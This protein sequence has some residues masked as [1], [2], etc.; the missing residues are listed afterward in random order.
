RRG[1][2]GAETWLCRAP[3]TAP[4]ALP[5]H[6]LLAGASG[7]LAIGRFLQQQLAAR[8]AIAPVTPFQVVDPG[9][10]VLRRRQQ[11]ADQLASLDGD[12]TV[13]LQETAHPGAIAQRLDPQQR[14]RHLARADAR[15]PLA[16]VAQQPVL[17]VRA[18]AA[19]AEMAA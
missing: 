5:E 16:L 3:E 7:G 4:V 11:L 6:Q 15:A 17:Q 10:A 14:L 18:R 9:G 12:E 2:A 19:E 13:P 1:R 8:Q